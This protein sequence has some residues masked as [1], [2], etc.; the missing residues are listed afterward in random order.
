[1]HVVRRSSLWLT[2][3]VPRSNHPWYVNQ[4]I[5]VTTKLS[6]DAVLAALMRVEAHFERERSIRDAPRTLDLDLIAYDKIIIDTDHPTVPHANAQDQQ[7]F[8]PIRFGLIPALVLAK[9]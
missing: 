1:M 8:K 4:V 5:I 3:P 2:E 6:P 9:L 7:G